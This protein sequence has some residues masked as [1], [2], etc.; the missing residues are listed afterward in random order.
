MEGSVQ[1]F[2]RVETRSSFTE[3][4]DE[5]EDVDLGIGRALQRG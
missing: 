5:D 4:E 2:Q 3:A 1:R